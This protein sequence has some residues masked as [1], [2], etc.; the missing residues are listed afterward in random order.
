VSVVVRHLLLP[1]AAPAAVVGLYFTPVTLFGCVNRGW[2]ALAI[3]LI[4]AMA[5]CVTSA[6]A[7]RARLQGLP[8][9]SRWLLSTLV[10]VTPIVLV[11][12]PLG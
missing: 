4:S 2:L 10:L 1:A 11:L 8:S 7:A 5:A 9:T 3:V 6:Q 12:G